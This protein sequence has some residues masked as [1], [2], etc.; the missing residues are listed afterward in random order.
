MREFSVV[1]LFRTSSNLLEP[2]RTLAKYSL[3]MLYSSLKRFGRVEQH[4]NRSEPLYSLIK[5]QRE[6][7]KQGSTH[8]AYASVRMHAA[9]Q[10][11]FIGEGPPKKKMK[12]GK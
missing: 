3:L 7:S 12:L 11:I 6:R 4:S 10:C 9:L 8:S 2:H 5:E 1:C